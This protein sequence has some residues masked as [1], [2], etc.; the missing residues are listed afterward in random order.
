MCLILSNEMS[1]L[2]YN[3]KKDV[4]VVTFLDF[5]MTSEQSK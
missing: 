4:S 1:I 2:F 3:V 5:L